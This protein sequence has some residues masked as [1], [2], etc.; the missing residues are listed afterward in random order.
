MTERFYDRLFGLRPDFRP[1]FKDDMVRQRG[2]LAAALALI[3]RN[4][5]VLG[6]MERPLEELGAVHAR[7]G[8][9]AEHYGVAREA[10]LASLA[11]ELWERWT[12]EL[13]ADWDNLLA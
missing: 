4:L 10:L 12:P 6:A 2:H 3:A 5:S 13:A 9:R 7:A 1:M 11:E 8:V